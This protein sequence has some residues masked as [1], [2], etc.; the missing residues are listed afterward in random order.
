MNAAAGAERSSRA[1]N[2]AM[3][4]AVRPLPGPGTVRV[5]S[6]VDVRGMAA[7]SRLPMAA[8][9]FAAFYH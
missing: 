4:R 2:A 9:V 3:A 7:I 1:G 8:G 5:R 6:G